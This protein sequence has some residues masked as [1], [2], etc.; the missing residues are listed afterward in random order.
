MLL[1]FTSSSN[2]LRYVDIPNRTYD[3]YPSDTYNG[4]TTENA[5]QALYAISDDNVTFS[6]WKVYTGIV[7]EDFRYIKF[8]YEFLGDLEGTVHMLDFKAKLDVPDIDFFIRDIP[9]NTS[10]DILFS[11]YGYEFYEPPE[12]LLV[13]KTNTYGKLTN[14]TTTGFTINSYDPTDG[15][16]KSGVYDIR[17][18]GY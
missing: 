5:A 11:D 7:D 6:D 13:T 16:P 8:K 4:L 18:H 9:I 17:I 3:D 14:V 1:D 10:K 12:I 2:V 15:T